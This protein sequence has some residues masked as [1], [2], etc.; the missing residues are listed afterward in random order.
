VG[1]AGGMWSGITN[2]EKAK[3]TQLEKGNTKAKEESPEGRQKGEGNVTAIE[4]GVQKM[5]SPI[6]GTARGGVVP[7]TGYSSPTANRD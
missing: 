5:Q 1:L 6:G 3:K 7:V 2:S 4:P